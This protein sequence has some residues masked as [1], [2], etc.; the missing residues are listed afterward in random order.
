MTRRAVFLDR[1]GT[2][3]E[4]AD[5]LADPGGIVLIEGAV[6]A[7]QRLRAEGWLVVIVTNQSGIARGL[8]SPE[9]YRRVAAAL[10][11]QLG[12]A[13]CPVDATCA[14]P[15]HPRFSGPCGCRKPQA[16][17][18]LAAS[19]SLSIDLARSFMI[20]DKVS[21]VRA[22]LAAGASSIL[23]RT[24]Y[25]REAEVEGD[26]PPGTPVVDTIGDAV[27]RILARESR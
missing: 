8:I 24:G 5:Y 26:L 6:E 27:D 9:Q 20:G 25:G 4:D 19:G 11:V 21:D 10:E 1:D 14:C 23:V 12:D 17:L 16:G 22:G 7:L 15:H 13:G 3:I 2:L 18:L